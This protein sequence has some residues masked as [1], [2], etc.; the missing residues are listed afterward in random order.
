MCGAGCYR[1]L[2]AADKNESAIAR[3]EQTTASPARP[4]SL[5]DI[6]HRAVLNSHAPAAVLINR[7][8]QCLYSMGPTDRYLRVAPG[9]ATLDLLAMATPALRTRLRLAIAK[10]SQ[11]QPR[12]NGG[13]VSLNCDGAVIWFSIDVQLLATEDDDL[14]LVCFLE[15]AAHDGIVPSTG[16]SNDGTRIAELERDLAATEVEL[17]AAMQNRESVAHEQKALNKEALSVNE[18]F[19]STNEELLT[20]KEELQSLNEELTALNGQLR[21]AL[22]R[23]RLTSDDLQNVLYSTNIGTLFLDLDLRIRFFTPAIKALFNVIPGDLGRPLADLHS[24]ATDNELLP[25][26]HK[27]LAGEALIEREIGAPN[28]KWFGRR[29]F[30]YRAHDGRVEGVVI[31]FADIT[32]RKQIA[33]ALELAK[34]DAERANLAKSRFLAAASHDLRQPLQSLTLL[35]ALLAQSVEGDKPQKLVARLDQT[36]GAMSGMLNA[37]LDINQIEA[38]VV[39]PKPAVFHIADI[40]DRLRDEFTY[41]AQTHNL[42]LHILP[43]PAVIESDPRLLEQMIRNLLGN[44]L[45][46]TTHGK[47]LLGV[48][49]RGARL[50]IEV[51][52]TGIGIAKE[53]LNAIFDEFHQVGNEARERS[54]GLGLGLSIVQRLGRLLGH[55]INVRSVPGKGSV[56]SI[57]VPLLTEAIEAPHLDDPQTE[58]MDMPSRNRHTIVIVDDDPDVLDLLEQ[59]LT[60]DGH[61]VRTACDGAAALKLVA[62][63]VIRPEILLTDYNLPNGK[64]GLELL[65]DLREMLQGD[66]PA[67]VL[68]GD[69]S[70]ETL[71]KIAAQDCIQ[72]SKPVKPHELTSAI[73][74]LAPQGV[75]SSVPL[76]IEHSAP[77]AWV[78][79]DDPETRATIRDVLEGDGRLVED[80]GSAEAFLEAY[81]PGA[82]GCLLVDVFLP[83]MSGVALLEKLRARGDHVPAIL[84]T[85]S[86]DVGLAVDAMR[87]GAC[88]FIEKPVGRTELLASINLAIGQSHDIRILDAAQENAASHVAGLTTRQRE[89]MDMVL[90]GHPSKNIAADLGI[91]QRTVENHRAAVMH[92]MGAK[93]LP[94]LARLAQAAAERL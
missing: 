19:Q 54:R 87:S 43:S 15:E 58:H 86:S 84:I 46:Y 50:R 67:I 56:F 40:F 21:E 34:L 32:E 3:P 59:L 20:S 57:T 91:S 82:E 45:Q 81:R 49:R 36:L 68:T 51:W 83:G 47:I 26:A 61:I 28:A 8:H 53:D 13:R 33:K 78:V 73:E 89:V 23:Q 92:K 18:G 10:A 4:S 69:I 7:K 37:L 64:D 75:R 62:G 65:A 93:S 9:Y 94:E 29:I 80:F 77:T 1:T 38:G 39:E 5:A 6:C 25:D 27:V 16:T 52:D 74:S 35:Q 2:M 60:G 70:R 79:D 71:A 44:A 17:Q 14:L 22:E 42:S 24:I 11:L 55:D 12:V 66:L 90:A 85:G 76:S 31:T 63:G 41:M 30:P 88:D 72:L 48:R